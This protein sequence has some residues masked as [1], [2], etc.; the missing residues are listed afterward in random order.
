M[1]PRLLQI[2]LSLNLMLFAEGP[3]WNK[4]NENMRPIFTILL[5]LTS[6]IATA[7][8]LYLAGLVVVGKKRKLLS[9]A[10]IISLLGTILSEA[11]FL[12]I[13]YNLLALALS[14]FVW[15]LLIKR[16]YK[17]NWLKATAIGILALI[18]FLAVTVL[19]ALVFGIVDK[20]FERFLY[21]TTLIL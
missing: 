11:F 20:I 13:P 9:D 6:L 15:L 19:L 8:L 16:L 7:I 21:I 1:L 5:F 4:I 17:T 3:W 10:F 14:L 12:F 18:I 2:M